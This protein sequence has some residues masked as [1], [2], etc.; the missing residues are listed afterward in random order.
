MAGGP[1]YNAGGGS[2]GGDGSS[3]AAF[4]LDPV[5]SRPNS[6]SAAAA[7][8]VAAAIAHST[9]ANTATAMDRRDESRS[10]N[11][12]ISGI[13]DGIRSNPSTSRPG[14][15]PGGTSGLYSSVGG[16]TTRA[17]GWGASSGSKAVLT[18]LRSLQDKIR[19]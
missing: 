6:A 16:E 10:S 17:M 9:T 7:A 19:K 2:G 13:R 14:E 11:P 18:A 15:P 3:R 4:G 5:T 8:A 1:R 12:A